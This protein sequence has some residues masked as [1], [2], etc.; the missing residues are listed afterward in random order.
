MFRVNRVAS[1]VSRGNTWEYAGT[2]NTSSNVRALPSRRMNGLQTQKRIIRRVG[3]APRQGK[4]PGDWH[5]F[6]GATGPG[7]GYT[8][9][10]EIR[11]RSLHDRLGGHDRPAAGRARLAPPQR[12]GR[13]AMEV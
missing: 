12:R 3:L 1:E 4:M 13:R 8:A 11:A 10:H 7:H 6:Q 9:Q 5:A 2:N